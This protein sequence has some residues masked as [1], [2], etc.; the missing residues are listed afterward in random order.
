MPEFCTKSHTLVYFFSAVVVLIGFLLLENVNSQ[1]L[2]G[3]LS[4][5]DQKRIR[6]LFRDAPL[7]N[8]LTVAYQVVSGLTALGKDPKD[9]TVSC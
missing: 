8:D 2:S 1:S 6:N 4:R 3:I 5:R 7:D 9:S